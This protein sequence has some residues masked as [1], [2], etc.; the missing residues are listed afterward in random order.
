MQKV[1]LNIG[2]L[3]DGTTWLCLADTDTTDVYPLAM[4]T[5]ADCA[6]VFEDFMLTQG[7]RAVK[8]PTQDE[9]DTMLRG[10]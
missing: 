9:I 4:F 7:Y 6:T 5:D 2:K 3:S 1:T 10:L 8:L